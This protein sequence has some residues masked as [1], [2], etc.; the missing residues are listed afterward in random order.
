MSSFDSPERLIGKILT[1]ALESG[2]E[3]PFPL[4]IVGKNGS[5]LFVRYVASAIGDGL[6]CGQ[7]ASYQADPTD[8]HKLLIFPINAMLVD[9]KGRAGHIVFET[10][11]EQPRF[12]WN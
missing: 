7:L 3:L 8:R 6:D 1:E 2:F 5:L 9:A 12:N 11:D 4:V 10:E